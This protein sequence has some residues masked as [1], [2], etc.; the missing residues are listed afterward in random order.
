MQ[1]PTCASPMT[2]AVL[3]CVT[4]PPHLKALGVGFDTGGLQFSKALHRHWHHYC[5]THVSA[6]LLTARSSLPY[7]ARR[8]SL[9]R[10]SPSRTNANPTLQTTP[11]QMG[12]P[13][14]HLPLR[15]PPPQTHC[16]ACL[17]RTRGLACMRR[18]PLLYVSRR[19]LGNTKVSAVDAGQAV[20]RKF[21]PRGLMR[22]RS[23]SDKVGRARGRS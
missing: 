1:F 3:W 19:H 17:G 5:Q 11:P 12:I 2:V 9:H 21:L 16:S 20:R 7:P 15:G 18:S 23:H 4:L 14:V 10:Y 8:S 22:G 13:P 6:S